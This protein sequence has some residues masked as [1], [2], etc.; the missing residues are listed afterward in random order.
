MAEDTADAADMRHGVAEE[1]EVH[2]DVLLVVLTEGFVHE[3]RE[4]I[5]VGDLVRVRVRVRVRARVRVRVGVRAGVR[6]RVRVRVRARV[7]AG[8]RARVTN[9]LVDARVVAGSEEVAVE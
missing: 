7:R 2:G 6:V 1:D 9:L 3:R 8:V 4:L 5:Y